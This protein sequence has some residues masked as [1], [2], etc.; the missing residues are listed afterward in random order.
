MSVQLG[1]HGQCFSYRRH[2]HDYLAVERLGLV[3]QFA[4]CGYQ[5]IR[6]LTMHI[7]GYR[8][9]ADLRIGHTTFAVWLL[10][11]GNQFFLGQTFALGHL[12]HLF[13]RHIGNLRQSADFPHPLF[14]IR[15]RQRIRCSEQQSRQ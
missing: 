12:R 8:I 10:L 5:S 2:L 15:C 13:R 7:P 11:F 14:N 4:F 1:S 3:T 9:A 6:G